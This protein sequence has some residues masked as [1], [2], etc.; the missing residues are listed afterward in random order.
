V[1]AVYQPRVV[2][3][4]PLVF[5]WQMMPDNLGKKTLRAPSPETFF[6]VAR[7]IQRERGMAD[8]TT[9]FYLSTDSGSAVTAARGWFAQ[10]NLTVVLFDDF[11]QVGSKCLLRCAVCG[12]SRSA[13]RRRRITQNFPTLSPYTD[14]ARGSQGCRAR[15]TGVATERYRRDADSIRDGRAGGHARE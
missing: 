2:S 9:M 5:S 12:S 6:K 10:R 15:I 14:T 13:I 11:Y 7:M 8:N 4:N 1:G 3:A